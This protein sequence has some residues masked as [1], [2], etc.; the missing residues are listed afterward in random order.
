MIWGGGV[1]P[2]NF[3]KPPKKG[4]I[5]TLYFELFWTCDCAIYNDVRKGVFEI[6]QTDK[7]SLYYELVNIYKY[8]DKSSFN[9]FSCFLKNSFFLKGFDFFLDFGKKGC[10]KA[11]KL[12]W[13]HRKKGYFFPN[14]FLKRGHILYART[15]MCTHFSYESP[16]Q[17]YLNHTKCCNQGKRIYHIQIFH[18]DN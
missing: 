15:H 11:L 9:D 13:F 7:M 2:V 16:L 3:V 8:G 10:L 1:L 17:G 18:L 4:Y 12:S 5:L 14:N 6:V